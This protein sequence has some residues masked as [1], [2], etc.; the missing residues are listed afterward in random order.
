MCKTRRNA[1]TG[2]TETHRMQS[3]LLNSNACAYECAK[4]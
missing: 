4:S 2:G 1:W 3:I